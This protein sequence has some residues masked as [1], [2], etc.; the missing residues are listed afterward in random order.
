MKIFFFS[1]IYLK[2][3]LV[4]Q[5]K[6]LWKDKCL[7]AARINSN[8]SL[9]FRELLMFCGVNAESKRVNNVVISVH[10]WEM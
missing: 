5:P 7:A 9:I 1:I 10:Y 6:N 4:I 2:N 8:I 3:V